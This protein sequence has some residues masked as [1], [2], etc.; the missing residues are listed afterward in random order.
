MDIARPRLLRW[1]LGT[2]VIFAAWIVLGSILTAFFA[3]LWNL[4]LGAL[5]GSDD[6]SIAIVRGYEPWKAATAIL[7]SFLPLLAAVPF[8]QRVILKQP[9]GKLFTHDPAT[10]APE[11][12][13]GLLAMSAILII[14]SLPDLIINHSDYTFNFNVGKFAPYL[15][16]ALLLIPCQTTAEELLFRGWI[17]QRLDNGR[18]SRWTVSFLGGVIFALPHLANPEVNGEVVLAALGYGATGFMFAW[19][20]LRDR[21]LG[22]AIG[23]HAANNILSALVISSEDS[24]LPGVSIWTSPAIEWRSA[25]LISIAMIPIFIWITGKWRDKVAK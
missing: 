20:C 11:I 14:T 23:A 9:L 21:S 2:A 16:V 24:A 3:R 17:Q 7:V 4:D 22:V 13:I 1:I 25:T 12:G 8:A 19:V 15:V 10:F 5:S 6:A 18:R